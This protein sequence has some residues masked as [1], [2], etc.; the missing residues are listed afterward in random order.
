M[1]PT[2]QFV[3][4]S[5]LLVALYL[6]A[7]GVKGYLFAQSAAPAGASSAALNALNRFYLAA[8]AWQPW[9]VALWLAVW[10]G[11]L[12]R[13]QG[14][15]LSAL[16]GLGLFVSLYGALSLV[17]RLPDLM[18]IFLSPLLRAFSQSSFADFF[19]ALGLV[20]T[21]LAWAALW[22]ALRALMQRWVSDGEA[23]SGSALVLDWSASRFWAEIWPLFTALAL[24][25][26]VGLA[27]AM[28]DVQIPFALL[29]VANGLDDLWPLALLLSLWLMAQGLVG[30]EQSSDLREAPPGERR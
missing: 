21:M 6:L 19:Y 24:P 3:F 10:L 25:L 22:P 1:H 27:L 15:T 17:E 29:F 26:L 30:G 7:L 12:R 2:R 28:R 20:L 23:A 11:L 8:T 9:P 18:R 4:L 5:G 14:L 16:A 13:A